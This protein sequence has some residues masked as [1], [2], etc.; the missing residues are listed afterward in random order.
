MP[1]CILVIGIGNQYRGD[2]ANGI[3]LARRINSLNLPQVRVIEQAGEGAAL[4]DAWESSGASL[5]I[6]IDAVCSGAEPGT[7]YRLDVNNKTIPT[8]FFNYS[9]HAFSLAEAIELAR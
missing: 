8:S 2:D 9:T 7:V 3:L 6:L 5:V 1:E 4:I